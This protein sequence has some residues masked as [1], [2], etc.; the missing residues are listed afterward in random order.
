[1]TRQTT[2]IKIILYG[3]FLEYANYQQCSAVRIKQGIV[4]DGDERW[5]VGD[6]DSRPGHRISH[7]CMRVRAA[8]RVAG[9]R[10]L[11]IA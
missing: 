10:G 5:T 6:D 9:D 3:H 11:T 4:R 7:E 2:V 1:M 8:Q